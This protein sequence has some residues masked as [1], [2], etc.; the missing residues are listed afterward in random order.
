LRTLVLE[1]QVEFNISAELSEGSDSMPDLADFHIASP[2]AI[3]IFAY[4]PAFSFCENVCSQ[5]DL[6]FT[7]VEKY[8]YVFLPYTREHRVGA[9]EGEAKNS[10]FEKKKEGKTLGKN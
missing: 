2:R 3:D 4:Q 10:V 5:T 8:L 1:L 6:L 7:V 9:S